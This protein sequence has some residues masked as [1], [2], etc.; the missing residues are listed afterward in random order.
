Q[1]SVGKYLTPALSV[2]VTELST[3]TK[4]MTRAFEDDTI[5]KVDSLATKIGVFTAEMALSAKVVFNFGQLAFNTFELFIITPIKSSV[6]ALAAFSKAASNCW[7]PDAW[8]EAGNSIGGISS[9]FDKGFDKLVG[10]LADIDKAFEHAATTV[11]KLH[12]AAA[13][14]QVDESI[15]LKARVSK[16]LAAMLE[17][18]LAAD[19]MEEDV[20]ESIEEVV[21][22]G[23]MGAVKVASKAAQL[24]SQTGAFMKGRMGSAVGG[25]VDSLTRGRADF[26]AIFKGMAQ[27]FMSFFIKKAL[28]MV[29]TSFIPGLGSILGG[30]FDTPVNDRMAARQGRDFIL[31]FISGAMAELQGGSKFAV[32]ITQNSNRIAPAGGGG[33]SGGGMV[34]V[35]MRVTGNVLSDEFV[36]ETIAPKLQKLISDGRSLVAI[37]DEN[38]TGGRSVRI[39]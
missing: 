22:L 28:F 24:M 25:M 39:D 1:V 27:D 21:T 35:N 12:A 17:V 15:A 26:G 23:T 7:N 32:N 19:E 31:H 38:N 16:S 18:A 5:D 2:L 10:N 4:S 8:E 14:P 36:E 34:V 20:G 30:M 29:V 6:I 11:N 3:F 9:E 37:Q 13:G 33:S